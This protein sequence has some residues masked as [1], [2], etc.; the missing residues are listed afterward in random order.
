MELQ[1]DSNQNLLVSNV[2]FS[3]TQVGM[4][5]KFIFGHIKPSGKPW[6][7]EYTCVLLAHCNF[8]LC[9]IQKP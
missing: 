9:T 8:W 5:A 1:V 3:Y 6:I 2:A 7:S 4:A